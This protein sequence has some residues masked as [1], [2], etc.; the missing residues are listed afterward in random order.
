MFE[1]FWDLAGRPRGFERGAEAVK[2]DV[3]SHPDIER[4]EEREIADLPL[5]PRW[6][7]RLQRGGKARLAA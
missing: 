6:P 3:L 7:Q 1:I 5:T 2:S 4:M